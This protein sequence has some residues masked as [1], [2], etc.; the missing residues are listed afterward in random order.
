MFCLSDILK[1]VLERDE[2]G[3]IFGKAP[4][5]FGFADKG[6]EYLVRMTI[7]A[8]QC[9]QRK[10]IPIESLKRMKESTAVEGVGIVEDLFYQRVDLEA[11]IMTCTMEG[12]S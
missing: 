8:L 12:Y 5:G 4:D 2:R 10:I 7:I 1:K 6:S 3:D 11:G 9:R